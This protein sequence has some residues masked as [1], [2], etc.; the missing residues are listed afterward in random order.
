MISE[1]QAE[2]RS[3]TE[4][5]MASPTMPS[6]SKGREAKMKSWLWKGMLAAAIALPALSGVARAQ[7]TDVDGCSNAILEGDYGFTV[8]GEFLGIVTPA[9]PQFFSSPVPIDGV[10]M[11]RFDGKGNL[12]QVD[13]IMLNGMEVP[14]SPSDIDPKTGFHTGESGHYT[15]FPDCTGKSELDL[16][17]VVVRLR[18]VLANQGRDIHSVVNQEHVVSPILGCNSST[19]CDGHCYG[20]GVAREWLIG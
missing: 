19:G 13:F 17:G 10:A 8:H 20:N 6:H 16:P 2:P 18:F 7:G 15:V 1:M 11:T 14:A 12:T 9:G 3:G 5:T 4:Q